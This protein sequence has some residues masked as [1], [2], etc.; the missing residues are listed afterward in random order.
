MPGLDPLPF[1]SAMVDMLGSE[2]YDWIVAADKPIGLFLGN[3]MAAGRGAEV[4]VDWMP[5]ATPRQRL[6]ATATFLRE[7]S[8][9]VK[10][11]IFC[12]EESERFFFRLARYR[13]LRKGCQVLNYYG[14][15]EHAQ[16]FYT[17]TP[18]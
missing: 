11:F 6:E 18:T 16:M 12:N 17:P 10:I 3:S 13:M 4:Q 9:T 2:A 7:V 8:K 5:W 15:G 1:R 14:G